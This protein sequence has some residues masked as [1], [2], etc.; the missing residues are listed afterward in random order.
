MKQSM[1]V[2]SFAC[3]VIGW[4]GCS[5]GAKPQGSTRDVP[6][7][8]ALWALAPAD[9]EIGVVAAGGTGDSL[10]AAWAELER[11][12][13]SAPGRTAAMQ[14][15]LAKIRDELPSQVLDAGAHAKMG[16]DL[17]HGAALFVTRSGAVV[18]VLPVVDRAAFVAATGGTSAP[19]DGV[20]RI[21]DGTCKEVASHYVCASEAA[22][23]DQVGKSDALA[24]RVARRPADLRGHVEVRVEGRALAEEITSMGSMFGEVRGLDAA[25]RLERGAFTVRAH[26][27]AS[28]SPMLAAFARVPGDLAQAAAATS[29]TGITRLRMPLAQLLPPNA[30][31]ALAPVAAMGNLDIQED[32]IEN[33]S[34]EAVA[35]AP[36]GKHVQLV[37]ELGARDGKRLQPLI[38]A[39]CAMGQGTMPMLQVEAQGERC[40]ATFDPATLGAMAAQ[41]PLQGPISAELYAESNR[42]G[43]A[44]DLANLASSTQGGAAEATPVGRALVSG[45]WSWASWY[46]GNML[47]SFQPSQLD[48]LAGTGGAEDARAMLWTMAH[49][50]ELG[51]GLGIREDG[52]H[53]LIH[54]GTQW[55]N[56]DEVLRAYQD[57]IAAFLDGDAGATDALRTL[58]ASSPDTVLG[59]SY[60]A[61]AGGMMA[62]FAGVGMLA[63]I[64]I[65]SYVKYIAKSKATEARMLLRK[66]YDGARIYYLDP[67]ADTN[68]AV[69]SK[70]PSPSVGPT[71]PP[72]TCCAQGGKCAPDAALWDHPTWRKLAFS[73]DDSHHYSYEYEVI[74]ETSEIVVRAYGDLDCD[75]V[76]STFEMRGKIEEG[77][78]GLEARPEL[79]V[80]NEL[81]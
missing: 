13:A 77:A 57:A 53:A 78:D 55:A 22:L 32:I 74:D 42:L 58:A 12:L 1:L 15:G 50:A 19:R 8:D 59:R 66:M 29:P 41:V 60:R 26:L 11:S 80:V 47:A 43:I 56:P 17:G 20:D 76:L 37:L 24:S 51:I 34:G 68:G 23:L 21:D 75:G 7:P 81:E 31:M 71:P 35:Y 79:R 69:A 73:V 3:S 48:S 5:K 46:Q 27:D 30:A 38:T 39:L 65:P 16:L 64:A 18:R 6:S 54:A 40:K 14:A 10:L 36:S 25:L 28:L 63:A 33:L 2:L 44:L 4:A 70:F 49:L 9:T 67:P 61:G 45:A 52:V 62:G 72:G